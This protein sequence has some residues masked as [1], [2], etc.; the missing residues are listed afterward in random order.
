MPTRRAEGLAIPAPAARTGGIDAAVTATLTAAEPR[1]QRGT[2]TFTV[3]DEGRPAVTVKCMDPRE[4]PNSE[5]R[6]IGRAQLTLVRLTQGWVPPPDDDWVIDAFD[7]FFG[8]LLIDW[9]AT[10]P[11]T[12]DD[13][14]LRGQPI[15]IRDPR[16]EP[17]LVP[18]PPAAGE[19]PYAA[20]R[21]VREAWE[22]R[23]AWNP[24]EHVD[25]YVYDGIV[26]EVL[27]R[28]G[29]PKSPERGGVPPP[30]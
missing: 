15:P 11:P 22:N 7:Q 24:V 13:A 19:D 14:A 2:W 21:A 16:P 25:G 20:A 4:L 1:E 27:G 8:K 10:Y 9:N 5:R 23:A 18:E 17:P 28:L 12:T 26:Q 30:A 29:P 6:R 3:R